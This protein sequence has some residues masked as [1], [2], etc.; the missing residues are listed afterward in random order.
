MPMRAPTCL[1]L[2]LLTPL[3]ALAG[4]APHGWGFP[5]ASALL[6]AGAGIGLVVLG[7]ALAGVAR[8]ARREAPR[9]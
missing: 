8:R 5:G 3:P 9:A 6:G 2:T 1:A 7:R 4:V